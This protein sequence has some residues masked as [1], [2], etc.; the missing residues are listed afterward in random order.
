MLCFLCIQ[1]LVAPVTDRGAVQRDIYLPEGGFLWQEA[2]GEQVFD[3]GT[4]L[5]DYPV[6]LDSVAVFLRRSS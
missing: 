5:E 6:P 1:V 2:R 3:G 4:L